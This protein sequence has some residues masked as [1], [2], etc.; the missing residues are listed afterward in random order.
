M[1]TGRP[2]PVLIEMPPEAGV[3][4]E[5]VDL[6]NPARIS[7]IVPS[8][9]DLR[10][11][12]TVLSISSM[13]LIFAGGGVARS[14]AEEALVRLAEAAN[15]PVVTSI[16]GKKTIPGRHPLPYGPCFGPRG[17]RK[18]VNQ[19]YG[20]M[21]YA[22]VAIKIGSRLSIGNPAGERSSLVNINIDDTELTRHQAN[23][24]PLH[25]GARAIIG[26]LLPHL[27]EAGAGERPSPVEAVS[28]VSKLIAYYGNGLGKPQYGVL[29]VMRSFIPE[30]AFVVWDVTQFGYYAR[31]HYHTN[32]PKT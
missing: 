23:S 2:S 27:T 5:E 28:K 25:G 21:Q 16:G 6:R 11:A 24:I 22:D 26:V 20:V 15:I 10:E 30:H 7:W 9:Q 8:P 31:T 32:H 14:D 1:R 17:E 19:L 3:E 18:E 29:K 4:R 13:P 12:A